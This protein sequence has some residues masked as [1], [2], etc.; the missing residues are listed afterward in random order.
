MNGN[1]KGNN[2]KQPNIAVETFLSLVKYFLIFIVL[3]NLVWAGCFMHYV[4]RTITDGA[5]SIEYFDK[6]D[7]YYSEGEYYSID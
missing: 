1:T 6:E 4:V 7:W 5:E 2:M 3:N